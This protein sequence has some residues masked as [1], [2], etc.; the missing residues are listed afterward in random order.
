MKEILNWKIWAQTSSLDL[1]APLKNEIEPLWDARPSPGFRS[2]G[3]EF[4]Q[5]TVGCMQ[6]LRGE[7]ETGGRAPL[8]TALVG[9][10]T[11]RWEPLI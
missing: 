8:A 4:F 2:R 6:Q 3:A 5:Y 10:Y 7:H 9:A 11:T 1:I